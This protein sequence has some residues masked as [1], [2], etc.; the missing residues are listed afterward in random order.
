MTLTDS[1][2]AL[3]S[4]KSHVREPRIVSMF[5]LN[6]Q[7]CA[8]PLEDTALW[9]KGMPPRLSVSLT[10]FLPDESVRKTNQERQCEER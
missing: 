5:I 7:T 8:L 1:T 4:E 6:F 2:G 10:P 9:R 3:A